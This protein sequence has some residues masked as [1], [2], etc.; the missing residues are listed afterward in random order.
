MRF[1]SARVQFRRREYALR[2]PFPSAMVQVLA[3]G[4]RASSAVPLSRGI[5]S[6]MGARA[7][8]AAPLNHGKGA[9]ASR[10]ASPSHAPRSNQTAAPARRSTQR[11]C[12]P[13]PLPDHVVAGGLSVGRPT[14][15]HLSLTMWWR[16][17]L[18]C[19]TANIKHRDLLRGSIRCFLATAAGALSFFPSRRSRRD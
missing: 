15:K 2:A 3:R 11:V 12:S 8:S 18:R 16:S 19:G 14:P 13:P 10:A 1:S 9:C 4:T 5:N 17:L 6:V 7:S